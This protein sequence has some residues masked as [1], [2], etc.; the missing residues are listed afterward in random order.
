MI[1]DI[2]G[3]AGSATKR[4]L[5]ETAFSPDNYVRLKYFHF[6]EL[7]MLPAFEDAV[8]I[9]NEIHNV[10]PSSSVREIVNQLDALLY[11][12]VRV[13]YCWYNAHEFEICTG[14]T[15]VTLSAAFAAAVKM[16]ITLAAS[17]CYSS[18]LYED[19][20]TQYSHYAVRVGGVRGFWD[21]A[22]YNEIIG[23]VWRDRDVSNAHSHFFATQTPAVEV[24]VFVV[25][26]DG[27]LT[28][29]ISPEVWSLGLEFG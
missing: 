21:G 13:M 22:G 29:Y 6:P 19:Q 8:T 27:S 14:T 3:T 25:G 24:A 17:T 5:I 7:P 20:L 10:D 4:V 15:A 11:N 1:L 9:G 18:S 28:E 23:K 26:R 12:A 2:E 16:P